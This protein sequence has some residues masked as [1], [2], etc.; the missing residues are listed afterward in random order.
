LVPTLG[1][2]SRFHA[3]V[4]SFE[5]ADR[6]QAKQLVLAGDPPIGTEL[7]P[8]ARAYAEHLGWTV[9]GA[10]PDRQFRL[11]IIV[12]SIAVLLGA[13]DVLVASTKVFGVVFAAVGFVQ[14]VLAVVNRRQ[15]QRWLDGLRCSRSLLDLPPLPRDRPDVPE[16]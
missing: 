12:S 16:D 2:D 9:G 11:Q 8:M 5:R 3:V 4:D 1:Q 10:Q 6:R 7:E 14:G 15:T 13:V